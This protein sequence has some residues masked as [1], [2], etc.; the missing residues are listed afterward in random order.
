MTA[1]SKLLRCPQVE[2]DAPTCALFSRF[3]QKAG[4]SW[5]GWRM[6]QSDANC[7]PSTCQ[8]VDAHTAVDRAVVDALGGG[9]TERRLTTV[10]GLTVILKTTF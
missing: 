4:I 2:E 9:L 10:L 3:L 1:E 7:S 6:T 5:T 8:P